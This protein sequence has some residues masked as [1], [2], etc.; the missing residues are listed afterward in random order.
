M[1]LQAVRNLARTPAFSAAVVLVL[2]LEIGANTA[3]F[4]AVHSLLIKPLPFTQPDRIVHLIGQMKGSETNFSTIEYRF[5]QKQLTSVEGLSA[6]TGTS[7]A[8]AGA[9]EPESY[10]GQLVTAGLFRMLGARA[11]L[12]RTF[13]DEEGRSGS[14]HVVV[15]SNSL[16]T[17]KFHADPSVIG[18]TITLNSEP[19][20]IIGV[21]PD[22]FAYPDTR[23]SLWVPTGL[24]SGI[25]K[26]FEHAH[27]LRVLARIKPDLTARQ[28]QAQMESL[29]PVYQNLTDGRSDSTGVRL[30]PVRK[31][32]L[33]D[34]ERPLL[35]LSCAVGLVLLIACINVANMLLARAAGRQRE[36]AIRT[37]LGAT[38]SRIMLQLLAE[39]AVL[40]LAGGVLGLIAAVWSI[41]SVVAF[42]SKS[43]PQLA[44]T[45]VD[46][47]VFA[48]AAG[49]SVLTA[50]LFGLAPAVTASKIGLSDV[51]KQSSR[52]VTG[53][54][55]RLRDALIFAEIALS[56]VVLCAA[57]LM[58]K[59]LYVL[60]GQDPGFRTDHALSL[61]LVAGEAT[62]PDGPQIKR[63][64]SDYRH[65]L[66]TI[67][68]VEAAGATSHLPFSGN[69]WTEGMEIEGRPVNKDEPLLA[70]ASMI[71]PGYFRALGLP[72]RAGRDLTEIDETSK[73]PVV[74]VNEAFVR[75]YF[76]DGD[77]LGKRFRTS[78]DWM[79]IVGIVGDSRTSLDSKP[80]PSF[81]MVHQQVDGG[82][83]KFLGRGMSFVIR[84]S[85]DAGS[86]AAAA[87]THL[88]ELDAAIPL[89]E[90]NRIEVLISDSVAEPKFRT[91]L[92]AFFAFVVLLLASG[93]IY[94]VLSHLVER[95]TQEIGVRLALGASPVDIAR[96]VVSKTG[97]LVGA[98]IVCGAA[99]AWGV[100]R[101][102]ETLLFGVKSADASIFV[103]VAAILAT[104]SAIAGWVPVRRALR[105]DPLV[106]LRYD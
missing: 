56:F 100:T 46:W 106:A 1:L 57:G 15:L 8:L 52:S 38:R 21:M 99:A 76:P 4:S 92:T 9:G 54:A 98:G 71:T 40:S 72:L 82:L 30:E 6:S 86:V 96:L 20:Q 102:L 93:G 31:F 68:G 3:I 34:A 37:A 35:V 32:L 104:V 23:Y 85:L 101:G 5:L 44:L 27:F 49:L 73:Q 105:V 64:M 28:V 53:S 60:Q 77:A 24:D 36:I 25:F 14:D 48:F 103:A 94:G 95:H 43:L 7:F 16:W 10:T 51:L 47:Q 33:G 19:Y 50:L 63:L 29:Y 59:S 26:R 58:L 91:S 11:A 74:I 41:D 42:G 90:V 39:A 81:Y 75:K 79:S 67:P 55:T 88:R 12:G 22:G 69:D 89:R 62:Y 17:S 18:R 78:P 65:R 61:N 97:V 84:T 2:A 13:L 45:R 80:E 66:L 83:V 70:Q 87:R